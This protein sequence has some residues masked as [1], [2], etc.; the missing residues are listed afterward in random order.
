MGNTFIATTFL[1]EQIYANDI[2]GLIFCM[3]GTGTIIFVSTQ[4]TEPI[5]DIDYLTNAIMQPIFLVC[6]AVSLLTAAILWKQSNSEAGKKYI[7]IDLS[8]CSL[9]G[10]F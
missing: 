8:L 1:G 2:L 10:V 9:F 3:A 7:L 5:I 6:Y 4:T